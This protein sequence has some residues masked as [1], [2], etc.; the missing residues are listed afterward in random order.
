MI[1]TCESFTFFSRCPRIPSH[2]RSPPLQGTTRCTRSRRVTSSRT[3]VFS[4][5]TSTRPRPRRPAPRSSRTRWRPAVSRTR[6]VS[7][8]TP[9]PLQTLIVLCIRRIGGPRASC[10]ARFGEEAG[11]PCCRARCPR[12]GVNPTYFLASSSAAHPPPSIFTYQYRCILCYAPTTIAPSTHARM[13]LHGLSMPH[14]QPGADPGPGLNTE[15]LKLVRCIRCTT[16]PVRA[17]R[18][19][20]HQTSRHI[21][22][23]HAQFVNGGHRTNWFLRG[24]AMYPHYSSESLPSDRGSSGRKDE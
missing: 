4:W 17:L 5:S 2:D 3:S 7:D 11:D 8:L 24:A 9:L 6:Y 18:C 14:A 12:P 10:C 23:R 19:E 20:W 22:L 15:V 13:F 1:S 16:I 21:R